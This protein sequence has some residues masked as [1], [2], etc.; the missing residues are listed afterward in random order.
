MTDM[1]S[2]ETDRLLIR[3]FE[4]G[5]LQA[6][7]HLFDVDLQEAAT[8]AEKMPGLEERAEWLQWAAR[9]HTQLAKLYQPPYGDRAVVL[10][11]SGQIIGSCGFVPSLMP[12][13]QMPN[14]ARDAQ[15]IQAAFSTPEVGLFYVIAPVHRRQGY[16]IEAARALVGYAFSVLRLKR[17]VATTTYDNLASKAVMQKLGMYIAHNPFPDPPYLQVVGVISNT[18]PAIPV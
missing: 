2:L 5:D 9:N 12:F 15:P 10:R 18:S 14:L 17:V 16:A 8:G 7:H 13:E 6:A 3:P 1:P 11:A 4:Q